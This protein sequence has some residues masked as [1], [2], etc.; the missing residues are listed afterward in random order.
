MKR[1]FLS[2]IAAMAMCGATW[3]QEVDPTAGEDN[4]QEETME[5]KLAR[6]RVVKGYVINLKGD[7]L[8]GYM[9]KMYMP[10]MKSMG[11]TPEDK[12]VCTRPDV[13][14]GDEVK[15]IPEAEFLA[16]KHVHENDYTKVRPSKYKGYVYD[17]EELNMRFES[18][19]VKNG[20]SKADMYFVQVVGE[21]ATGEQI[22]EFY[23]PIPPNNPVIG[24][25]T[26][27]QAPDYLQTHPA[28]YVKEKGYAMLAR[29][30]KEDYYKTRCPEVYKKW[31]NND[32][33]DVSEKKGGF[34]NK[35]SK[36]TAAVDDSVGDKVRLRAFNDYL[37]SCA[38][39]K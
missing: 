9:R 28:V 14:F 6:E 11:F 1:L 34:M 32:Y 13:Q 27:E 26:E 18:M 4:S 3:A 2:V 8:K 29:D 5:K 16:K 36:F 31:K 38:Y 23:M 35:L 21:L 12:H 24:P 10:T 7:T 19:K 15:F 20:Y 25:V 30:L 37:E 39:K 33:T 17:P 22:I